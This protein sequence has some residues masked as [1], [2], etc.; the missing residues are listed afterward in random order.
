M[1]NFVFMRYLYHF[2][3]IFVA[4]FLF[5][6]S[7]MLWIKLFFGKIFRFDAEGDW[8]S[9]QWL[10]NIILPFVKIRFF[11]IFVSCIYV[12]IFYRRGQG[13]LHASRQMAYDWIEF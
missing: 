12:V 5:G 3:L 4:I 6:S 2:D 11:A 10:S 13:E 1:T 9:L 8:F 7:L